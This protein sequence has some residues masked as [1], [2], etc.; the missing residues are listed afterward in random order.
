M[1]YK[2]VC[3]DY[4]KAFNVSV[5]YLER[6]PKVCSNCAGPAT[7]LSHRFRPPSRNALKKWEVVRFLH[8]HGFDYDHVPNGVS[9]APYPEN[10]P[11]A[12]EFVKTYAMQARKTAS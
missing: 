8:Q 4:R 10:L 3:F 6:E 7:L 5:D 11:A 1:G 12:K 9:Y 2:L